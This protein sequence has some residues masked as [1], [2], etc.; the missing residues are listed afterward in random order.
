MNHQSK[1]S[2]RSEAELRTLQLQIKKKYNANKGKI[3][4]SDYVAIRDKIFCMS[5]FGTFQGFVRVVGH[6]DK[7]I[8]ICTVA[9]TQVIKTTEFGD[10]L[11]TTT[12]TAA[13]AAPAKNCTPVFSL[14]TLEKTQLTPTTVRYSLRQSGNPPS[15][16]I[17]ATTF[18][19]KN[20]IF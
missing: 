2:Q 3:A 17:L 20:K 7:F 8:R 13:P 9:H 18:E 16:G 5:S 12:F 10:V 14:C 4:E 19:Q 11:S 6:T 1:N 15:H